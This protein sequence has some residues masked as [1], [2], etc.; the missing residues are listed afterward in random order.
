MKQV[1][2]SQERV[3]V[4]RPGRIVAGT[5]VVEAGGLQVAASGGRELQV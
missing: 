4:V 5:G 2:E 1:Q 3:V